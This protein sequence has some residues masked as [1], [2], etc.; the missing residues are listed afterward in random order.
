MDGHCLKEHICTGGV[1]RWGG[2]WPVGDAPDLLGRLGLI[3]DR[4]PIR[5]N[6]EV[7]IYVSALPFSRK[8]ERETEGRS[9]PPERRASKGQRRW[10][11]NAHIVEHVLYV[12]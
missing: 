9:M 5:P 6:Q 12:L 3:A 4:C 10:P 8:R 11:L 1:W 2:V 7:C